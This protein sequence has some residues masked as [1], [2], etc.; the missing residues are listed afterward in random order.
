LV[1][2]GEHAAEELVCKLMREMNLV[3]AQLKPYKRTTISG[4]PEHAVADLVA[5][6]HRR[7]AAW[8]PRVGE[9]NYTKTWQGWLHLATVD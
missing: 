3:A 8:G 9:I 1:C 2:A 4:E 7:A 5:R 6:L